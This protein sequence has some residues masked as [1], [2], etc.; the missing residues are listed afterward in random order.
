MVFLPVPVSSA[1]GVTGVLE[2]TQR[3][4]KL[5]EAGS[6]LREWEER[7]RRRG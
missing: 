1:A 5:S 2:A 7:V 4:S 6:V 3:S